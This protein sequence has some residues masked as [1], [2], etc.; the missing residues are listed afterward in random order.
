[1]KHLK[2]ATL[3]LALTLTLTL[4]PVTNAGA[5]LTAT[6]SDTSFMMNGVPVSVSEA[7]LLNDANYLQLRSIAVL[8]N[9]TA[10]QFNV[11]WD[12]DSGKA[13]IEPGKPYEG[14]AAPGCSD[15]NR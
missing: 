10:A 2:Q 6:P 13:V 12:S 1:M 11:T 9:G 7:Y 15:R 4:L 3:A 5:A 8:L 14:T